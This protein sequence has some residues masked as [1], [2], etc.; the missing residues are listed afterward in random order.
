MA[1]AAKLPGVKVLVLG[2]G[3]REHALVTGLAAD[4]GV[5]ALYAAPGNPGM[6]QECEVRSVSMTDPE[7]VV[8][9]AQELA[10]DLVVIGPEAPLVA[11]VGNALREAGVAVFG[12]DAAAAELEGS[13]AFAKEIMEAAGVP[14]SQSVAAASLAECE[15][16]FDR[17]GAPHVVKA[18]GLAAGKGVVVTSDRDEALAHARACLAEA[19]RVVIED[20]LDGPEVSLFVLCDGTT[21]VPLAPAQDFKRALNGDEGPNTGGMGAY[22]PLPWA[23]EGLVED[24]IAQVAQPVVDE[25]ARRG[26]PFVGL[27]YCGLA[28]TKNG[29]EV[30]EFNARFGDPETQAVLQRLT[31]PLGTVLHAA[32]AG[33]LAQLPP[34][35]WA[36]KSAVTVVMA[37]ENYPS[38]PAKGDV[39]TGIDQANTLEDVHVFHAGTSTAEDGELTTSGGRVLSVTALGADLAD[40]RARAYEAVGLIRWRGEHHRTDIAQLAE[41]NRITI[42]QGGS[43]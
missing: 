4:P 25:I 40:A 17:F 21:T 14:T 29:I 22:T 33:E 39:I 6:A 10:V 32:A 1:L 20:F 16:A 19:D 8:A 26:T 34:L 28:L 7:A 27:L 35:E 12:P 38:A 30:I 37:A 5:D 9:L 2:S 13:K 31:S 3:A 42:P 11:G 15:E 36:D 41:E 43:R 18:D 24:V 23:P